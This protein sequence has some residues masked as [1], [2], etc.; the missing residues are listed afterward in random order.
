MLQ[1]TA[2]GH[3]TNLTEGKNEKS[4]AKEG[5][6]SPVKEPTTPKQ[7]KEKKQENNASK[8][9]EKTKKNEISKTK[10]NETLEE[11]KNKKNTK[12]LL[13]EKPLDYDDDSWETVPSK[14]D[15]KKKQESPAKKVRKTSRK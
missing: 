4:P 1:K 3:V 15:K 7:L 9:A 13:N 14:F 10:R 5:K 8:P 2:N 11:A 6:R 12:K